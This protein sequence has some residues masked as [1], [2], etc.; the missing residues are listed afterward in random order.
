M[1]AQYWKNSKSI[2]PVVEEDGIV[3]LTFCPAGD[4]SLVRTYS[5]KGAAAGQ[6]ITHMNAFNEDIHEEHHAP[7]IDT[8]DGLYHLS[9][10]GAN[11]L[12]GSSTASCS[13]ASS[14]A[15][16][17]SSSCGSTA[18]SSRVVSKRRSRTFACA[19]PSPHRT[20]AL[21]RKNFMQTFRN[22]G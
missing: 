16:D 13:S 18:A 4:N 6:H 3:G 14:Q 7:S 5:N 21:V 11:S 19:V 12:N 15:G 10:K 22:I 17:T 8:K 1:G 2:L 9:N 20:M